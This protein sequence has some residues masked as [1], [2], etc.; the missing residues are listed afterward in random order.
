MESRR[1]AVTGGPPFEGCRAL[2]LETRC[3]GATTEDQSRERDEKRNDAT[4]LQ[5]LQITSLQAFPCVGPSSA[6][7]S[8]QP[9]VTYALVL[10]VPLYGKDTD[11]VRY[12]VTE[13]IV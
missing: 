12:R 5:P 13:R 2:G 1:P 8:V 3:A 11:Q 7:A 10:N 6:S 9:D 4:H